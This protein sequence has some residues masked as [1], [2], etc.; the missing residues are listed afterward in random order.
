MKKIGRYVDIDE[1]DS[2]MS[3]GQ[4]AD[5][6]AAQESGDTSEWD[7]GVIDYECPQCG[8][9]VSEVNDN[10]KNYD[11]LIAMWHDKARQGD[12][13]SRFVFEYIAFNAYLKSRIIL[14]VVPDRIAIQRFKQ[15]IQ[16]QKMYMQL[17]TGNKNLAQ[18]WKRIVDELHREPLMNSSRDIDNSEIDKYWNCGEDSWRQKTELEKSQSEGVVHSLED[19]INMVEFWYSV[20]N[21]LFHGGK[22]PDVPRD[23]FLV[24]YAF[25]TL[26]AFMKL[27]MSDFGRDLKVF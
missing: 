15:N 10:V 25:L 19:W 8:D 5:Y 24:K 7:Y 26:S 20:R 21:N 14:D 13:F 3:D 6:W 18:L 23:H 2:D 27:M 17:V 9:K 4:N 11:G 16:Y 12:F 22:S 1:P